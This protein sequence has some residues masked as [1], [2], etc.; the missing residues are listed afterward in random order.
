[1]EYISK[2]F[3]KAADKIQKKGAK[4]EFRNSELSIKMPLFSGA[5]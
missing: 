4:S 2:N 5:F 1:M 3:Y